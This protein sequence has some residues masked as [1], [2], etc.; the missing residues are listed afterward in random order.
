M[1]KA[2][3]TILLCAIGVLINT[4]AARAAI[5]IDE[6]SCIRTAHYLVYGN[7]G[8]AG[9]VAEE[10]EARY[11]VYNKLFRYDSA[12]EFS[13]SG[14]TN[15]LVVRLFYDTQAYNRYI[16]SRLAGA[17]PFPGA[18]YLHY[19]QADRRELVIN[20]SSEEGDSGLPYQAFI[21]YF[22]AF[23][24]NPPA[25]MQEGCAVY[26][27]SLRYSKG[28]LTY[29]EHL[30]W[31]ETVKDMK[32]PV[33]LK[34]IF[35]ADNTGL[36]E[37]FPALAWSAVSFFLNSG[38]GEYMRAMTDCFML[39]DDSKTAGENANAVMARISRW[40]NMTTVAADYRRYLNSRK[41]FTRLIEEGQAA[42]AVRDY[43]GAE[44]AF[45]TARNQRPSHFAPWY[46][47]GL[48]AYE[49]NRF[50]AAEQFYL[51]GLRLGADPALTAYALGLN[52]AKAG[53]K[54][55][56]EKYLYEAALIAPGRYKEK[57]ETVLSLIN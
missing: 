31:L 28:K 54:A 47:L 48:L 52:A 57:A 10:M 49:E 44:L 6:E 27:S 29:E 46:F 43:T 9:A 50:E 35:M 8:D 34:D 25:W 16:G 22:R 14:R 41:T 3:T 39:L 11:A 18:V 51:A 2:L 12:S 30:D 7:E 40:N 23:V 56:A 19:S 13:G 1:R 55:E 26:F 45:L 17:A 20:R 21:Q 32:K 15:P 33:P 38:N 37:F 5:V 4:G 53:N 42:Y 36:P 24:S